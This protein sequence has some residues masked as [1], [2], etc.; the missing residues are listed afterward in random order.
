MPKLLSFAPIGVQFAWNWW[1]TSILLLLAL[2]L[3]LRLIGVRWSFAIVGTFLTWLSAP[4]QWWSY[5]PIESIGPAAFGGLLVLAG[6]RVARTAGTS[7]IQLW[8][9]ALIAALGGAQVPIVLSSYIIWSAPV[10]VFVIAI[11][12]GAVIGSNADVRSR[13]LITCSASAAAALATA[14]W[15]VNYRAAAAIILNTVFPGSRRSEGSTQAPHWAGDVIWTFQ[16]HVNAFASGNPSELAI[17]FIGAGIISGVVIFVP[18]KWSHLDHVDR[19][20]RVAAKVGFVMFAIF[21]LWTLTVWPDIASNLNPLKF[22]LPDRMLQI[23]GPLCMIL[24][25]LA[26]EFSS[27]VANHRTWRTAAIMGGVVACVLSLQSAS[28]LKLGALP[29]L[30]NSDVWISGAFFAFAIT[31]PFLFRQI[32]GRVR[33]LLLLPILLFSIFTVYSVNPIQQG[34]GALT[35]SP[36]A[37]SIRDNNQAAAGRWATDGVFNDALILAAGV[38][39]LSGQQGVGPNEA[40][41]RVLD[42]DLL[43]KNA[44][45]RGASY[46]SFAWT[47]ENVASFSNPSPDIISVAVSPCSESVR[48]LGLKWILTT[49]QLDQS[50]LRY[51]GEDYWKG[52]MLRTYE[53]VS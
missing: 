28:E 29:F 19:S 33:M 48:D 47:N 4:V 15:L 3:L 7:K 22:V 25:A 35:D 34:T 36:I 53:V 2:P 50:C 41:W 27:V 39:E 23:L 9:G 32:H 16:D 14:L 20:T 42:P 10:V 38:P 45:N 40:A 13:I 24:F 8:I 31:A 11:T 30:T 12:M 21:L 1:R 26:L 44:W 17:G 46:I 49:G 5:Y 18:F 52:Q 51:A 6:L 43:N 37:Q